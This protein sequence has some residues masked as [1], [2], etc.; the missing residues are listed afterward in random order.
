MKKLA[1][2]TVA[3][4]AAGVLVPAAR[5]GCATAA[6]MDPAT[7]ASVERA[8]Q[9]YFQMAARGDSAGLRQKAVAGLAADFAPVEAAVQA[10]QAIFAAAQP[11]QLRA[12]YLLEAE[13]SAPLERA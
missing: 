6:D 9:N 3:L 8:A 1:A 11:P 13:G 5:A 10:H 2:C 12:E 4:L 7:R